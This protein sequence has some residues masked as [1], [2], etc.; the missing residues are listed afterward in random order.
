MSNSDTHLT[1][2]LAEVARLS[3]AAREI[4]RNW[5]RRVRIHDSHEDFK[6]LIDA[7]EEHI[8]SLVS[9]WCRPKGESNE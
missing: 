8:H 4:R 6:Q 2:T 7:A 1:D 5:A 3:K 9:D